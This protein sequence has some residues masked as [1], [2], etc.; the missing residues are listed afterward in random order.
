ACSQVVAWNTT[1]TDS[2]GTATV[3]CT[4]ASG[5]TFARGTTNVTCTATDNCGN[6]TNCTFTV[7]V[8]DTTP[9]QITCPGNTS[10]PCTSTNGAPV[11][12][13]PAAATENCTV[14]PA[15][16]CPPAS[17]STFP[18]GATTV[19]CTATDDSGNTRRRSFTVTVTGDGSR[20]TLSITR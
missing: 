19:T 11:V 18:R 1:A 8:N 14:V 13:L 2:C 9:P 7:T 16:K 12:Y 20:P 17:G 10:A 15:V 4:P 6:T 3:V 5:S